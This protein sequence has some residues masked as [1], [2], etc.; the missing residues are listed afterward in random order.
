M[1][2]PIKYT[3]K[4]AAMTPTRK[5]PGGE[6]RIVDSRNFPVSKNVAAGAH[7]SQ[8]RRLARIALASQCQ[9]VAVLAQQAKDA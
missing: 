1:E 7:Y 8:A 5:T 6:V 4:M 9:R 2:S 3:F